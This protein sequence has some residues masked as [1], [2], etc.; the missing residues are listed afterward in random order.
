VTAVLFTAGRLPDEY[1]P[2][3]MWTI[4]RYYELLFLD[5]FVAAWASRTS[6]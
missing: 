1:Y 5:W 6:L 4:S 3:I 2:R